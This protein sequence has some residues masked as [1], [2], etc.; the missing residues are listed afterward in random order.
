MEAVNNGEMHLRH[1]ETDVLIPKLM[2][3]KAKEICIDKVQAF[4]LCCKETGFLMV[5]K[6]REENAALKDCLTQHYRDPAFYEICKQE[7]IQEKTEFERTGIPAK[8]RKQ[9]LPTSM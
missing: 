4:N 6:C 9:K 1:V 7:Y 8:N 2:R 3:E 5:V